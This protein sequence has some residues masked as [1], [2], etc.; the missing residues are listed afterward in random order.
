[1]DISET[2]IKMCGCGE[3][4]VSHWKEGFKEGDYFWDGEKFCLCG[5]DYLCITQK[6]STY[7]PQ[8]VPH[9]YELYNPH[10]VVKF[11]C[12]Q[13]IEPIEYTSESPC[14]VECK[15]GEYRIATIYNPIWLPRQDQIQEMMSEHFKAGLDLCMLY[16][17]YTHNRP[18]DV[19]QEWDTWEQLLLAYYMKTKH[20]KIWTGEKW[21]ND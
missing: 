12:L 13:N 10:C 16:D 6:F 15:T 5:M 11:A 7:I 17:W 2:Y 9:E 14:S 1:M 19:G 18:Y 4:Q 3:I 8:G 20:N 21:E